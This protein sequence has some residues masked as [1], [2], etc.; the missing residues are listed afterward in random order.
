MEQNEGFCRIPMLLCQFRRFQATLHT[1][2]R[3]CLKLYKILH[4]HLLKL[5][6]S[7]TNCRA[8]T[9]FLNAFPSGQFQRY[10]YSGGIQHILCSSQK[11]LGLSRV[12]DIPHHL[13]KLW[14]KS[15]FKHQ[16]K[17]PN[18]CPIKGTRIR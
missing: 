14:L 13:Q 6:H 5:P 1:L 16:I 9:S 2:V 12:S 11:Y 17:L 3:R 7:N 4:F 10:F 8:T 18:L 15:R